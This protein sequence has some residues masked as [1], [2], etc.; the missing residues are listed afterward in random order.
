MVTVLKGAV[1]DIAVDLRKDSDTFG[2]SYAV[3]LNTTNKWQL[4]VPRGFGHGFIVL[5]DHTEFFYKCDNFYSKENERGVYFFDETLNI[6]CPIPEN[7][8]LLSPKDKALPPLA[9]IL[10]DLYFS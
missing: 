10:Q 1:I 3:E 9:E 2:K 4:F 6:D 5:E 8:R 7:E